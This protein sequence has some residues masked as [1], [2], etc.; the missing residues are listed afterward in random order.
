MQFAGAVLQG[1]HPGEGLVLRNL[2]V[3]TVDASHVARILA[4]EEG[5]FLDLKAQE[6]TPAKLVVH[7]SAF[8]NTSGGEIYVGIDEVDGSTRAWRGFADQ[9]A[10]NG[11]LQVLQS[12]FGGAAN[13]TV[14]FLS[15]A[16]VIGLVLHLIIEK[17]SGIV[18]AS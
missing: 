8:A 13:L 5:H 10:A 11:H 3:T 2:G 14:E 1:T 18:E 7:A 6:I 17:S 16:G 15:G 4:L 9:E 12:A